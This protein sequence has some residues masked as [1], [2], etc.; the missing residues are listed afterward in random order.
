KQN[1]SSFAEGELTQFSNKAQAQNS[2]L[3]HTY[4]QAIANK[5]LPSRFYSRSAS[6]P[7][8]LFLNSSEN[9]I[10]DRKIMKEISNINKIQTLRRQKPSVF[11]ALR[12][13]TL[14]A[15]R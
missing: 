4:S 5:L 8:L 9:V 11:E 13:K 12:F 2:S 1:N 7:S 10:K 3:I 15:L 6:F 14:Q